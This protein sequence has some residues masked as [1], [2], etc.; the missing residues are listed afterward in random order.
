MAM[1]YKII[2][3]DLSEGHFL[4]SIFKKKQNKKNL[5]CM[6]Y[7]LLYFLNKILLSNYKLYSGC[8]EHIWR[9]IHQVYRFAS[10]RKLVNI[11]IDNELS[12]HLTIAELYKKILLFSLANPYHLSNNE[13]DVIW[14]HLDTWSQ[15]AHL[16][17]VTKHVIKKQ[18]SFLIK[19]FSDQP[20]FSRFIH[21]SKKI[22]E[23]DLN[24]I[25]SDSLWGI[26]TEKLIKK[27]NKRKNS[28]LISDYLHERLIRAWMGHNIRKNERNELIEPVVFA[29]G[30][31]S[32]SQFLSQIADIPN[33]IKL[34]GESDQKLQSTGS[35]D[36]FQQAF[37]VDESERG[38]RLKL[39][40]LSDKPVS[41]GIGEIIAIKHFDDSLQL[42]YLRWMRENSDAEIEFGLESLTRF[43]EPVQITKESIYSD[44]IDLSNVI[45][46][47][48][49]QG[50]KT[51]HFK[52]ILFTHNFINKFYNPKLENLFLIHKTGTVKIKL[53]QKISEALDY[54]LYL[55]EKEACIEEH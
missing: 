13:M 20:P 52:P 27:I 55:F 50:D 49:F 39:S 22:T 40:N 41:F 44:G 7:N 54:S 21:G 5:S 29:V 1:G 35:I 4:S 6:T 48:V 37:L 23:L 46:C 32:I 26:S 10:K 11:T 9:D 45:D 19:P 3:D 36:I 17:L 51:H 25:S 53:V 8:S 12:N 43:A 16:S 14:L 42:G 47:F 28:P 15:Y 2:I 33:I 31:S 18:F 30:L 34:E 38:I 24:E